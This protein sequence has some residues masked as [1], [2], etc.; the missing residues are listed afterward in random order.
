MVM[1]A[2]PS[3]PAKTVAELIVHA[4]AHAG[5]ISNNALAHSALARCL[6]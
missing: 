4:K 1:V 2:H 5:D 3:V 6:T